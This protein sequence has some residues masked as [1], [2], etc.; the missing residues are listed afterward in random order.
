MK[1]FSPPGRGVFIRQKAKV[2]G[3]NPDLTFYFY[4]L[5][6]FLSASAAVESVLLS[7]Q[8]KIALLKAAKSIQK[9]AENFQP[10][11]NAVVGN[12]A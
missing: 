2:K 5:P 7:I 6:F 1:K 4:L 12:Q 9:R 10:F 3:E 8:P 11:R